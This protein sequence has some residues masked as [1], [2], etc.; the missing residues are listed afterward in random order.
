[1][2]IIAKIKT[3]V[4]SVDWLHQNLLSENLLIFDASIPKV[5][6][7]KITTVKEQIP[8]TQFFDIKKAF[9]DPSGQFP[10]TIPSETQFETEA[11][12]L[13]VNKNSA[14][15]VYDDKGLYSSARVWWLFKLFGFTNVAILNG[16]LPE[17]VAQG[18]TTETKQQHSRPV[19]DFEANFKPEYVVYLKDIKTLPNDASVAIIDAR[20][21]NRFNCEVPEP[22]EGLRSGTIPNSKNIPFTNCLDNGKLKSKNELQNIFSTIINDVNKPVIFTCGS[23]ITACILDLAATIAGYKNTSVYD[24]SW[25]EYGSL[26]TK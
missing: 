19:G 11:R 24:G 17:W 21:S 10:N 25:T 18:Y 14:I 4:V 23:G 8:N 2:N 26:I 16:G 1:M 9:S 3:P 20:A 13:G 6:A 15:I 7:N 12:K 22:R 5:T